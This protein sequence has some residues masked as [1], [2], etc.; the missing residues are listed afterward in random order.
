MCG[1]SSCDSAANPQMVKGWRG[2]S[3]LSV[4]VWSTDAQAGVLLGERADKELLGANGNAARTHRPCNAQGRFE[5]ANKSETQ[6]ASIDRVVH[7]G[8]IKLM[9]AYADASATTRADRAA[10]AGSPSEEQSNRFPF[11]VV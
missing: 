5:K 10:F 6:L 8:T 4:W 7:G 9:D 11:E 3:A 2:D 1:A